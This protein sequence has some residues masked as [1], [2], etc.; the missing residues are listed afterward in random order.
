MLIAMRYFLLSIVL[1]AS[2]LCADATDIIAHRGFWNTT[3]SAQ[4]SRTSLQ[5]AMT[6]TG[7]YGSEMDL[8]LTADGLL[9]VHHDADIHGTSIEKSTFAE[10]S[11]KTLANGESL[12]TF[13]EFLDIARANRGN[14]VKLIVEIKTHSLAERTIEAADA[15]VRAISEAGLEKLTEYIA[16]DYATC[17]HLA[18]KGLTVA[19]LKGDKTPEECHADGISGIDYHQNDINADIIA[20]AHALGMSVNVWTVSAPADIARW[21]SLGVDLITTD[22]PVGALLL[23]RAQ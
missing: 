15:A 18:S 3:A 20:R 22:N 16:F 23:T 9:V 17:R 14:K 1:A 6:L 21:A 19:Y 4:N 10:L 8:W 2:V 5:N 11:D 7:T 12:P 13:S